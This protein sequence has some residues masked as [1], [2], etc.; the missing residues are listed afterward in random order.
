MNDNTRIDQL[1]RDSAIYLTRDVPPGSK[2]KLIDAVSISAYN[3]NRT[4]EGCARCVLAAVNEH[5]RVAPPEDVKASIRASTALSAGVARM[6]ETCGALLGG[7]MALGLE[8]GAD[9]LRLFDRYADA[10]RIS[11]ELFLL[12]RDRYGTVK[13]TDIQEKLLGRRYNFFKEEDRDAWYKEGGLEKCPS[14]CAAAAGLTAEII[15]NYR[16]DSGVAT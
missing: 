11:R 12:F 9:D 7:I 2:A 10:M 13:C 14:V 3:N 6:G 5:L 15:L 8:F 16:A 4:Y 1:E